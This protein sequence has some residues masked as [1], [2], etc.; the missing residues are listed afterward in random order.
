MC[1]VILIL[2]LLVTS[3][4]QGQTKFEIEMEKAMNEWNAAK[5]M[6]DLEKVAQHFDRIA[7]VENQNWLPLYYSMLMR[8]LVSFSMEPDKAIK[9]VNK[10]EDQFDQLYDLNEGAEVLILRGLFRTVKVAKDPQT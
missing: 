3:F 5:F 2:A 4:L 7:K 9:Q 1:R 6:D 8:T 10:I